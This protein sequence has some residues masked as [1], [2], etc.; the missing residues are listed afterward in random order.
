MSGRFA[1]ACALFSC[2]LAGGCRSDAA[3]LVPASG[4]AVSATEADTSRGAAI[5]LDVQRGHWPGGAPIA[6]GVTS[7][8]VTIE[9]L[10]AR[11]VAV[12]LSQFVLVGASGTRYAALPPYKVKGN[13]LDPEV[14]YTPFPPRFEHSEFRAAPHYRDVHPGIDSYHAF[15]VDPIYYDQ[16]YAHWVERQLPTPDMLALALPEGVLRPGGLL[17]GWLYFQEVQEDESMVRLRASLHDPRA[18][19]LVASFE[20]PLKAP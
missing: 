3:R 13:V 15:V 17:S 14:G 1:L 11:P 12:R 9:N 18:N 6:Q 5:R 10:S 2:S 20:I 8:H 19:S 7:V 4:E 16:Y